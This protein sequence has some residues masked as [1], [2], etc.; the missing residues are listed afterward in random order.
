MALLIVCFSCGTNNKPVSDA[1]K[2][3]IKAEVKN[4][5]DRMFKGCEEANFE[6][7]TESFLDSP[8]FVYIFNG[9]SMNYQGVADA[10]KP[11]FDALIN[12]KVTI[13][14]EK[15]NFLNNST[16]IYTTNCK[17]LENYKD[18]H[19]VLSDPMVIQVTFKNIN[20]V[21]K[22]ING[23]ES[24]VRQDAKNTETSKE[25]NQIELFKQFTGV[26]KA[27]EGGDTTFIWEGKSYGN[28]L[29]VNVKYVTKGKIIS[30]GKAVLSYNNKMDKYIQSRIMKGDGSLGGVMWFTSK[31]ICKAIPFESISNPDG[32]PYTVVFEFQSPTKAIQT[33]K[34]QGKPDEVLTFTIQK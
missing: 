18:G 10:I 34:V 12:Q 20:G 11:L 22:A 30:E 6:M 23:V 29:D 15:Y 3:K 32:A 24:S 9:V 13:L 17:F 26:F 7:A 33:I 8:D 5:A 28:G 4:V 31:N 14:D 27:V 19:A 25:L 21:W 1:Q 16:V 2:E